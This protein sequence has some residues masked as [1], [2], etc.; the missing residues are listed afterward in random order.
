MAARQRREEVSRRLMRLHGNVSA[1]SESDDDSDT[2]V[3]VARRATSSAKVPTAESAAARAVDL[4]GMDEVGGEEP[5]PPAVT[6][7]P[8]GELRRLMATMKRLNKAPDDSPAGEPGRAGAW[9]RSV[10]STDSDSDASWLFA[11]RTPR[12]QVHSELPRKLSSEPATA[13]AR[14]AHSPANE[15]LDEPESP[16]RPV[17]AAQKLGQTDS[18]S[19]DRHTTHPDAGSAATRTT[20]AEVKK[21][22]A[23]V[24]VP[25]PVGASAEEAALAARSARALL[26]KPA[27][28]SAGA[29]QRTQ[30]E[31]V[32]KGSVEPEPEPEVAPEQQ[33]QPELETR[34]ERQPQPNVP[35]SAQGPGVVIDPQPLRAYGL[36]PKLAKS[37]NGTLQRTLL[38]GSD[39]DTESDTESSPAAVA[40]SWSGTSQS[41]SSTS[42]RRLDEGVTNVTERDREIQTTRLWPA[43]CS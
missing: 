40:A 7:T 19:S 13:Q 27:V 36:R 32:R 2:E 30:G 35:Q 38:L 41:A 43:V 17:T 42:H 18:S 34:P 11:T 33:P 31:L 9:T 39:S 20:T 28:D 21:V 3:A 26:A 29:P 37:A 4:H 23:E 6:P 12:A 22:R 10:E 16:G 14:A 1:L 8:R 15:S 5:T 24:G 25:V